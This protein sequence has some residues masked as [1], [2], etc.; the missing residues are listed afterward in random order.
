MLAVIALMSVGL[1]GLMG[2][3]DDS[4]AATWYAKQNNGTCGS[5]LSWNVENGSELTITGYG[6]MTNYSESSALWGGNSITS[7]VFPNGL[8]SIGNYAFYNT[9]VGSVDIPSTV[10]SIGNS[11]FEGCCSITSLTIPDSVVSLGT[12]AF[13]GITFYIDDVEVGYT[14]SDL[15][16]KTWTGS[17]DGKL[18]SYTYQRY[19]ISFNA[20]GG[21]CPVASSMTG[22]DGTLDSLPEPT[23]DGY[24][25]LGWFTAAEGGEGVSVAT[26]FSSDVE[27]YAHWAVGGEC[28]DGLTWMLSDGTL[29]ISYC[30]TGTGK[31]TDFAS[32]SSPWYDNR[33]SIER[34]ILGSGV[35]SIGVYA[36]YYLT[37]LKSVVLSDTVESISSYSFMNCT[38]L[39]SISIPDSVSN[40]GNQVWD[41]CSS[42]A[43]IEVDGSNDYYRSV[44]GVLFDWALT[45]ILRYPSA[46]TGSV[47]D[48]PDTVVTLSPCSFKGCS[49]L[50]A[51]TIPESVTIIGNSAFEGCT[52]I[53]NVSI[54][55]SVTTISYEAFRACENLEY[56]T[57]CDG[58][59]IIE[60]YA[61]QSCSMTSIHIPASVTVIQ[62]SVFLRCDSLE[63]ITVD[64]A[65]EN[66]CSDDGV[67]YDKN[68]TVLLHYPNAKPD[69]DLVLPSTLVTIENDV[70][71]SS[72]TIESVVLPDSLEC[73]KYDVFLNCGSLKTI[74]IP[75][76]V[77][78]I[79]SWAFGGCWGL[80]SIYIGTSISS[81]ETGVFSD[82]SFYIDGSLVER[83]LENI[84][85][86]YWSG[87]GDR[88]LYYTTNQTR[89]VSFDANGGTATSDE[90]TVDVDGKLSALPDATWDGHYFVGWY[91]SADGGDPITLD[92]VFSTDA[93]VY[94]H[95]VEGDSCGDGVVWALSDGT[96]TLSYVGTG[97]GRMDD[98]TSSEA[99]WFSQRDQILSVII[100]QG[101][102]TIGFNAFHGCSSVNSVSI[103]DSVTQ[104]GEYA[105][106]ECSS[107]TTMVIPGTVNSIGNGAFRD[108]SALAD[109]TI[110]NG[111]KRLYGNCFYGCS[112]LRTVTL[113][114]SIDYI[115]DVPFSECT[116]LESITVDDNNPAYCSAD[117]VL[118]DKSKTVLIE[119]PIG[120]VSET[121][122]VPDSVKEIGPYSFY[123]CHSLKHIILSE[124]VEQISTDAFAICYSLLS[125]D[126]P[127]TVTTIG[128]GAFY[129][130]ESLESFVMPDSVTSIGSDIFLQC[131]ALQEL[132]LSEN[133]QTLPYR[134]FGFCMS[135]DSIVIPDSVTTIEC[136]AFQ[137]SDFIKIRFGT[138]LTDIP[139]AGIGLTFYEA[140]GET[141]LESTADNLRG[142]SFIDRNGRMVLDRNSISVTSSDETA[143]S[144]TG[145]GYYETGTI[146]TIEANP[147]TGYRF[148]GWYL[149]GVL[150]S[151]DSIHTFTVSG[152]AEYVATFEHIVIVHITGVDLGTVE[153]GT[154]FHSLYLPGFVECITS[155]GTSV[156]AAVSWNPSSYSPVTPGSQTIGGYLI[157]SA[158]AVADGISPSAA[159]TVLPGKDIE[160]REISYFE[161]EVLPVSYGTP[162][163]SI[164]MHVFAHCS[165]GY[166]DTVEVLWNLSDYDPYLVGE[167]IITGTVIVP[168]GF[169]LQSGLSTEVELHVTVIAATITS[170]V[171]LN[172]GVLPLDITVADIGLPSTIGANLSDGSVRHV[173]VV[174]NTGD[175]DLSVAGTSYVYGTATIPD[176]YAL[177]AGCTPTVSASFVLSSDMFGIAD[178]VFLIDTTGSMSDE[179][180]NVRTN[181]SA[182]ARNLEATGISVR[183]ALVEY[184]DITCDGVYSTQIRINGSE[185]WYIDADSFATEI[186]RLRVDGGGDLEETVID[187]LEKA[188]TLDFRTNASSFFVVVTDANYKVNNQFGVTG[189]TQEIGL[190]QADRINVSVVTDT[191]FYRD[192][193]ALVDATGGILVNINGSFGRELMKISDMIGT[194][195]LY[196]EVVDIAVTSPPLDTAY[197]TGQSFNCS[198][199]VV[200]ATYSS[201]ISQTV[202]GYSISPCGPLSTDISSITVSYRGCETTVNITV[203][204]NT[205]PVSGIGLDKDSV[206]MAPGD[207]ITLV[208]TVSPAGASM[209]DVY[210]TSSNPNV[211]TVIDGKVFA[212]HPGTAVVTAIAADGGFTAGC[213]VTVESSDIPAESISLN[214]GGLALITGESYTLTATVLPVDATDK[215]VT[216]TSSDTSV[217]TVNDGLVCAVAP[218]TAVISVSDSMGHVQYCSVTVRIVAEYVLHFQD[219]SASVYD[220]RLIEPGKDATVITA[221]LTGYDIGDWY[222]DDVLIA[223]GSF[224]APY[225]DIQI[226][227]DATKKAFSVSL[228]DEDG[229]LIG[230]ASVEYGDEY[231]EPAHSEKESDEYYT[232]E[233]SGWRYADGYRVSFPL[234][235]VEDIGI[236]ECY[237]A[238]YVY[239]TVSFYVNHD[240]FY[241]YESTY[242]NMVVWPMAPS[243]IP[244]SP[245]S[246][247][248]FI[249]WSVPSDSYVLGDMSIE[250][251]LEETPRSYT[252]TYYSGDT[253]VCTGSAVHGTVLDAYGYEPAAG[254]VF[255]CWQSPQVTVEDGKF[256]MPVCDVSLFA[257]LHASECKVTFV[258]DGAVY[259]ETTVAYGDPVPALT[260]SRPSTAQYSY[261]F[262]GWYDIDGLTVGN[263]CSDIT[264]YADFSSELRSY[265][266]IYLDRNGEVLR[267]D[268]MNYGSE[269]PVFYYSE[270]FETDTHVFS[271]AGWNGYVPG[272]TVTGRTVFTAM[273]SSSVITHDVFYYVDGVLVAKENHPAGDVISVR[274]AY[275]ATGI[276]ATPWLSDT[277]S[278]SDGTFVM[279]KADVAFFSYTSV[280][281]VTIRFYD[282][283]ILFDTVVLEYGSW[284]PALSSTP[285]K[286]SD[287][288]F[289]YRFSDWVFDDGTSTNNTLV[290]CDVDVYSVYSQ[291]TRVYQV[292]FYV[293]DENFASYVLPY[294]CRYVA[295]AR[296]P[297]EYGDAYSVS[298]FVE[299][300]TI[301]DGSG[302]KMDEATVTGNAE[303]YAVFTTSVRSYSIYYLSGNDVLYTDSAEY[304]STVYLRSV[305]TTEGYD[306][307]W[308]G[309]MEV[310]EGMFVMPASDVTFRLNSTAIE[311]RVVFTDYDGTVLYS[312]LLPYGAAVP[313]PSPS[314][315]STEACEYI[316]TGWEGTNGNL[317]LIPTNV[318]SDIDV[319]AHY[320]SVARQYSVLF[321]DSD[322]TTLIHSYRAAYGSTVVVPEAPVRESDVYNYVFTGWKGYTEGMT[323]SG[324]LVFSAEFTKELVLV[325]EETNYS[326]VDTE[327]AFISFTDENIDELKNAAED[328]HSTTLTVTVSEGTVTFD[329]LAILSF[330]GG[331]DFSIVKLDNDELGS[332]VAS[333][334]NGSPVYEIYFGD[335]RTFN[336]GTATITLPYELKAGEDPSYIVVY[337]ISDG[338]ILERFECEY[339]N[340][341]VSFVTNHF[342]TYAIVNEAPEASSDDDDYSMVLYIGIVI[343]IL[344]GIGGIVIA[345]RH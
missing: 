25:F 104:I 76:S 89:T 173:P 124:T 253:V 273:F 51:I 68:K 287:D 200:T 299:W 14:L 66:Y 187:A 84:S 240:L 259:L 340:G 57:I 284:F 268:L 226:Y 274:D 90:M 263:V 345:K 195:M 145:G 189:M 188:R 141:V 288:E 2:E 250:A 105:F 114:E 3:S 217:A 219:G 176:G 271:F 186:G 243:D 120:R 247:Y 213:T 7:V 56:V 279:P 315:E 94:A 30:G 280:D 334:V 237:T 171:S 137:F 181:V 183:W 212:K 230:C 49:L 168:F 5:N 261:V 36:F 46:K 323:V 326:I 123:D 214:I 277:V 231:D 298:T 74:N 142:Q 161:V 81:L 69:T 127:G 339:N 103:S 131:G 199:M 193:Q 210:W 290:T 179:I 1:F 337:Y 126:M 118:F 139:S 38:N 42:L 43:A 248:R 254:T 343:A 163:R 170:F 206:R 233:F 165:D 138:G 64:E 23:Y 317:V 80:T 257:V 92:T 65:N 306:S 101:V 320:D 61:F 116:S 177:A 153:Y 182:F 58:V 270:V 225:N 303:Y 12:S 262:R 130:C 97:T 122:V 157:G 149:D 121:Y 244:S 311:Y 73:I 314:R 180:S 324:R 8:T 40:I 256:T 29:T 211:A 285:S 318:T 33:E 304:G 294:G 125:I 35:K 236:Y 159:V 245:E 222:T 269:I 143:G 223:D 48:I 252:Y 113:P 140:D 192:Y 162:F 16:G 22:Q 266:V 234:T 106:R 204:P 134:A 218:G 135:L 152:N 169:M 238:E 342:S 276:L 99:P 275:S 295:P 265:Y 39:E 228:Y 148:S 300:N 31:M 34:V 312:G 196:G 98:Y 27:V 95:W 319:K 102:T 191:Y 108:C 11:S 63:C 224:T 255:E 197:L 322:G 333:V 128:Y 75:D 308:G 292:D 144:V 201:G 96:L 336:E 18:Y 305:P 62:T 321:Y 20:N 136:N 215:S 174:W 246:D 88:H 242:G 175:L 79:K 60:S 156:D 71:S 166:S 59:A 41:Y 207:I 55:G 198:G 335:N 338:K 178:I 328:D 4:E 267:S 151:V 15:V 209:T 119:Y 6:A 325:P 82:L 158:Y 160:V 112:S 21:T 24:I 37:D 232:Y 91:T 44:D 78:T 83:T 227:A 202:T 117:G 241:S 258:V 10:T 283:G 341:Y 205:V 286:A 72:T 264:L 132:V 110:T 316:F 28:G 86:K 281:T 53:R 111:V 313:V 17:G 221:E 329:S 249:D 307:S 47:Y 301:P 293:G 289:E 26:E 150:V 32:A 109:L 50:E 291:Q 216:W 133:L 260:A 87:T 278:V 85:G 172:M 194:T 251:V 282:Q 93:T 220:R 310:T 167:Q 185:N 146:I 129:R 332:D 331:N 154:E 45:S 155:T 344:V 208:A 190:L 67:L 77:T 70:F 100:G 239:Y 184:R 272:M 203:G 309:D 302:T 235:V 327:G 115:W 297:A 164:P 296:V 13:G 52:S 107:L 330:A 9:A 229:V 19:N 54:P 147:N